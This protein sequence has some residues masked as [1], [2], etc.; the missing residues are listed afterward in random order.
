MATTRFCPLPANFGGNTY[1]TAKSDANKISSVTDRRLDTFYYDA[2]QLSPTIVLDISSVGS[3]SHVFVKGKSLT[4]LA[5]SEGGV[6]DLTTFAVTDAQGNTVPHDRDDYQN[7][8][9][10]LENGPITTD[11]ISATITGTGNYQIVEV[12]AINSEIEF[13]AESRFTT[14]NFKRIHRAW[15]THEKLNGRITGVP[16]VNAEPFRWE[17]ELGI[18]SLNEPDYDALLNFL[19][20]YP[21]F[22]LIPEYTR[23]P[24]RVF[25]EATLPNGELQIRYLEQNL[26]QHQI[27]ELMVWEA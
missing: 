8:L 5:M 25:T 17:L 13:D 12:A 3:I 24:D 18:L 23:Y 27:L 20:T 16:P 10:E 6:A 15:Q 2:N 26:K 22:C 1:H 11:E 19:Y 9:F 4:Y 7:I 14:M 21:N